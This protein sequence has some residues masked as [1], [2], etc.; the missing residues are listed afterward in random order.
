VHRAEPRAAGSTASPSGGGGAQSQGTAISLRGVTFSYDGRPALVD[1]TLDVPL[2]SFTA[3][4]GPNGAGK[5]TVLRLLLGLLRPA[6]GSVEV[7][8]GRPGQVGQPIGYVPQRI[9]LPTGFPLSVHEV[10]LMGRYG[11]LGIGRRPGPDDRTRV[12]Q[13]LER[14]GMAELEQERFGDLSGG[15]QQ[16]VLIAR[17]LCADPRLLILDEPTVGL[18]PAARARFY[19]LVCDL[20]REEGLTLL[21]ASHDLDVV[22]AHADYVILL[23]RNVRA[24]GPPNSVLGSRAIE[25]SYGFPPPHVHGDGA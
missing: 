3:L 5:T 8:G 7:L 20:Q 23:D 6:T 4:I 12:H 19:T 13:A 25:K 17:A 22:S 18:D 1:V 9:R 15:Q 16:R 24:A 21:C 10:V 11:R 14:V 2:R